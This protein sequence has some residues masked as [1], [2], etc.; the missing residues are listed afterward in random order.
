VLLV[1]ASL[2]L[3]SSVAAQ[4]EQRSSFLASLVKG[5]VFDPTTYAPA[6]ISYDARMRD[7]NSSQVFF[8]NGYLE[9]NPKFTATGLPQDTPLSYA[10]GRQVILR[11]ALIHLQV[12]AVHNA[13]TRTLERMLIERFPQKRKLIRVLGWIER[14]AF[15]SY[16]SYQL[17]HQHYRQARENVRLAQMYGW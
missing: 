7:W 6:I 14:T 10:E 3:P 9:R 2:S 8:Q 12:S 15:A 1:I 4:D 17:S 11:D 16:L 5:V 13:T